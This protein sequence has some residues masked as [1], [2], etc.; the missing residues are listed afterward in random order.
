MTDPARHLESEAELRPA[1]EFLLI[2][3]RT[4]VGYMAMFVFAMLILKREAWQLSALDLCF[5]VVVA[6]LVAMR[7]RDRLPGGGR[8]ALG[9][10][11]AS[12]GVWTGAN[13]VQLLT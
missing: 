1:G 6:L 10:S 11:L 13:A 9:L 5:W 7:L 4:F 12:L 2:M 8:F 3:F